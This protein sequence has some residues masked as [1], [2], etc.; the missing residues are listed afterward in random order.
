MSRGIGIIGAGHALGSRVQT[1][2]ELCATT[3]TSTTPQ[4]ILEKT[5][6]R[7]RFLVSEAESAS[8]LSLAAAQGALGAAGITPKDLGLIVVCTFSGDY[9]FPPASA[10]LHLDL[11]AKGAQIFDVQANC[12][13]FVTGLTAASDRMSRDEDLRFA[14]V[15]GTEISSPFIDG[16]DVETAIFFSDGAGAAVLGKV[17]EGAGIRASTFFTDT[18]NYETVRLRGGG[19]SFPYARA[20]AEEGRKSPGHMEMNG[21]ATWKQAV[22]HLPTTIRRACEKSGIA[23]GDV[24]HFV[25]H[26][27]NLN[28]IQYAMQKLR[29][30]EERA[31][32]NVHEIGNTGSASIAI[33][34]SELLHSGRVR[35]GHK[36]VLAGVG[37]GFNF[38]AS[39]WIWDDAAEAPR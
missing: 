10:K 7:R 9:V 14:L 36:V 30:P 24:D 22:T 28:L 15:V 17:G 20:I 8:S 2:E 38:G 29:V 25:F 32:V 13:G 11:G 34:L 12:A 31:F 23:V 6:I 27:A 1:N 39:V 33:A 18:Q 16:S 26:Q 4:W 21:L 35:P 3:L 19:S 37:A 5:G